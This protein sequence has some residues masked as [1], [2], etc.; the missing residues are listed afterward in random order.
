MSDFTPES[1]QDSTSTSTTTSPDTSPPG[2]SISERASDAMGKANE[3]LGKVDWSQMGKYGK[4]A[5]II[6]VVIVA[7]IIIKVVIDTINFFPILPGLLELLGVVVVGQWGWQNL[8]TS[9]KRT[10]VVDKVQDLR[11]EYLG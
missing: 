2:P 1:N 7:Q 11:K 10:A 6:A 3:I 4:A 9:E 5:G 8:T